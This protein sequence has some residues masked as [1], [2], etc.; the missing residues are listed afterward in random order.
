MDKSS[1]KNEKSPDINENPAQQSIAQK[2]PFVL[3]EKYLE[4]Q[5]SLIAMRSTCSRLQAEV[6]AGSDT[7]GSLIVSDSDF[8]ENLALKFETLISIIIIKFILVPTST[9]ND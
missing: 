9:S 1:R 4:C 5:R 6:N 8:R 3:C 2:I 7:V